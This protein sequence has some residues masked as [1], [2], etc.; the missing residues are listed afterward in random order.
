MLN[1]RKSK[2]A[3]GIAGAF[4][5]AGGV[6]FWLAGPSVASAAGGT[7]FSR[8]FEQADANGDGAVTLEEMSA[9][10]KVLFAR[11]DTNGD[12]LASADE[13]VAGV[14]REMF[15]QLDAD[16][17]GTVSESEFLAH[18]GMPGKRGGKMIRRLD[19]DGDGMLNEA[20]I[21]EA[22]EKMFSKL[23]DD[24][25][26]RIERSELEDARSR[27]HGRHHGGWHHGDDDGKDG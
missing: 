14:K 19:D 27:W 2:V 22:T 11:F 21:A 8:H 12:G 15:R 4:V 10:R 26:G 20:E 23:D 13:M 18:A 24:G 3:V 16:G 6:A 5:V 7:I 17:D 1:S 25:D 9:L